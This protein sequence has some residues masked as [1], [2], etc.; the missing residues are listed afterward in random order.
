LKTKIYLLGARVL[1]IS[2]QSNLKGVIRWP[3]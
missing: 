3:K 2:T 1:L